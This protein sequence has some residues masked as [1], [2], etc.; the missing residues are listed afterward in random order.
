[1]SPGKQMQLPAKRR[2]PVETALAGT[3]LLRSFTLWLP[4]IPDWR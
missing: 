4:L 2:V 1:M 3:M